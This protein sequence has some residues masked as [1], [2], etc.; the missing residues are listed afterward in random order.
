MKRLATFFVLAVLLLTPMTALA[1]SSQTSCEGGKCSN[2]KITK[3]TI[4]PKGKTFPMRVGFTSHISGPVKRV[5]YIVTDAKTGK[6]AGSC[7]SFC[8]KCTKRGICTCSCIIKKPGTYNVKVIAHGPK[9]CCVSLTKKIVITGKGP[10]DT[11]PV[12]ITPGFKSVVSKKKV[13]FKDTSKGTEPTKWTWTF[14]D[15]SKSTK[16]NPTHTYKKAG[17]YNVCLTVCS[18]GYCESVCKKIVVK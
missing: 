14:G 18:D 5:E 9:Q 16:Q 1:D 12:K 13:T 3:V 15:G 6:K 2:V 7:N 17:N 11:E 4:S 10:V 8:S